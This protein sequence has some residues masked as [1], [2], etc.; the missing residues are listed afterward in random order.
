MKIIVNHDYID[1][2]NNPFMFKQGFQ[3]NILLRF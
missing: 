2:Q 1:E 3:D